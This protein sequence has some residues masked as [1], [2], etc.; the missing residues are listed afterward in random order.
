MLEPS[1]DALL[2]AALV[3]A[4]PPPE[5]Q[6]SSDRTAELVLRLAASARHLSALLREA[7]AGL[8]E[9]GISRLPDL[10][11]QAELVSLEQAACARGL[12]EAFA[13]PEG[14]RAA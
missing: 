5:P 11:A 8:A 10:L 9:G 1:P 13:H 3:A 6:E 14:R 2:F 12:L 4:R 7:S